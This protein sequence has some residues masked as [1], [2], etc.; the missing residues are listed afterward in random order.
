[1]SGHFCDRT[2][3]ESNACS[4]DMQNVNVDFVVERVFCTIIHL[5]SP[6]LKI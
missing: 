1:V 2:A 3:V 6:P 4:V 5:L